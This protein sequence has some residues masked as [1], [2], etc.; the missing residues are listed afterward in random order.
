MGAAFYRGA[1]CCALVFDLT[2][3]KTLDTLEQWKTEFLNQLN[4]KDPDNFPFVVIGNKCDKEGERKVTEQK[5]K[6]LCQ[7]GNMSYFECSAKDNINVDKAFEEV[8]RLAFKR[9][10]KDDEVFIPPSGGI[11][12]NP[13]K[14]DQQSKGCC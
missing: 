11:K 6:S 5:A 1:E 8:S 13:L 9:E 7:K 2:D 10:Q 4:P 3:P 12:I 14:K